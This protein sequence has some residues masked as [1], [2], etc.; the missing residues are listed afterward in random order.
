[1]T[2]TQ[3]WTETLNHMMNVPLAHNF[4]QIQNIAASLNAMRLNRTNVGSF[5]PLCFL[6]LQQHS[7][8]EA[9]E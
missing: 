5:A 3:I 8:E 4:K 9:R 1:M 6:T 7:E 2:L